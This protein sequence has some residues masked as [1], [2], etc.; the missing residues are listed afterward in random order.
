MES[1]IC[2]DGKRLLVIFG[3]KVGVGVGVAIFL[4]RRWSC[5]EIPNLVFT[6][7]RESARSW[8]GYI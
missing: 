7:M 1:G 8:R 5:G 6:A 3:G 2:S 4:P